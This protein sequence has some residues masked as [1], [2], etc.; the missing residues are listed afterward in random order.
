[1]SISMEML[2]P[3]AYMGRKWW[4][5]VYRLILNDF[6]LGSVN[7]VD[8]FMKMIFAVEM[9]IDTLQVWDALFNSKAMKDIYENEIM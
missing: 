3:K 2:S 7:H 9:S 6:V 5:I 4:I 8:E 1:M